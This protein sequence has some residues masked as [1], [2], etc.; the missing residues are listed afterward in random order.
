MR[1]HKTS[2]GRSASCRTL[3]M[4][5]A[6]ILTLLLHAG[7]TLHVPVVTRRRHAPPLLCDAPS[8]RQRLREVHVD[9][10]LHAEVSSIVA[11]K[12]RGG[13]HKVP[14]SARVAASV[15][16][17]LHNPFGAKPRFVASADRMASLPSEGLPEIAFIG[18]SNVGK[19]SLLNALTGVGSLA[20]VSDKPGKTQALNIF[21]LGRK[22]TAFTL[23]DMPGYG[24]AFAKDEAVERWRALSADYLN[25]RKTLKLVLVLIDARVGLKPSDLQMLQFLE[26]A[27]VKYTLVLTKADAAGPP[28]RAAQLAALTLGS[29]KQARHLVRPLAIVS[30]RTGAG[31]GRL[32]RRLMEVAVG[33]D[34]LAATDGGWNVQRPGAG[35]GGAGRGAARG[36]SSGRGGAPS[37]RGRGRGS[38]RGGRG[39]RGDGRAGEL[40]RRGRVR[41]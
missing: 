5:R 17:P 27:R 30:A 20:K 41:Q 32:Q 18:R 24:F 2:P 7:A 23:V 35:R 38:G 36:R 22:D 15:G 34:P 26:A 29:V 6:I 1:P 14:P 25:T 13:K 19:S 33:V 37:G 39:G 3:S 40:R 4:W 11:H 16:L 10:A 31:V 8:L 21:E 28:A 9:P 12:P